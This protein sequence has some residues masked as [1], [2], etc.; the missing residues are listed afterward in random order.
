MRRHP[1]ALQPPSRS[2]SGE[3]LVELMITVAIM[4]LSMVAIL[5]AIWTTL[6]VADFNSKTSSA[7]VVLRGFAETLKEPEATNTFKYVPCTV[8]GGEVTYPAY[9]PAALYSHYDA[10]I[11]NIRYLTGYNASNEPTWADACPATD[12]GLQELT[13]RVVGPDNDPEVKGTETVT[14]IKRNAVDDVPLGSA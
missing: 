12:L 7:D 6:R 3:T 10:T 4:G 5:G 11:T 9:E 1:R 13:L 14:V 2:E 8:P